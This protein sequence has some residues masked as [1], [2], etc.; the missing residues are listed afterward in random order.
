MWRNLHL[1]ICH[2]AMDARI[3]SVFYIAVH[4]I[5]FYD[6]QIWM[7]FYVNKKWIEI[8]RTIFDIRR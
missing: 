8:F 1:I 6:V 2:M 5:L 7:L 3:P 4:I